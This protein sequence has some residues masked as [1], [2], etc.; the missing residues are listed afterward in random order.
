MSIE[1][2]PSCPA[3]I[4]SECESRLHGL[5]LAT[6]AHESSTGEEEMVTI[7]LVIN[8]RQ[9]IGRINRQGS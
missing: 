7:S 9:A 1:S 2:P 5:P 6:T 8:G 3:F 4:T